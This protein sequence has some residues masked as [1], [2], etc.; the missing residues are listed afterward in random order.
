MQIVKQQLRSPLVVTAVAL[1]LGW[2]I[3][4][5]F[6]AKPPGISVAIFVLLLI[7]ALFGLGRWQQKLPEL[8]NLWL[9][10]PLFFFAVMVAV[11]DN[12]FL[13]AMN[14]LAVLLLLSYLAF[15][16]AHGRVSELDV[17]GSLL[18][19]LRV[20]LHS[21]VLTVPLL[22]STMEGV[23]LH[24]T[25]RYL[26]PVLRG[27]LLA[28]P[29]LFVF[30]ALLASA[31]L[32]FARQLERLLALEFLRGV[33]ELIGRAIIIGMAAWGLAGGLVYALA[34]RQTA[35]ATQSPLESW[36]QSLPRKYGLGFGES[37][38]ILS[39][40]NLLFLAFVGLQFTYL[41]GGE[42]HLVLEGITYA[43]Y[44][45]RGFFELV[46]VAVLSLALVLALNWATR[47][48]SKR[49]IRLFNALC[50]GLMALVLV[51]LLSAWRRMSL[52]EAAYGFTELRL[53]VFVFMAWLTAVLVWF[54]LTLWRAPHCFAIGLIVAAIGYLA[55]LDM[56][57]PDAFIV[58]Q[59]LARYA[60]T[61]DLDATYLTTLSADAVPAL[62]LALAQVQG[63][64]QLVPTPACSSHASRFENGDAESCQATPAEV[65]GANLH[66]R[67]Q[68]MQHDRTQTSWQSFHF[69]RLR[70]YRQLHSLYHP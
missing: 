47:R 60:Q 30:T 25:R 49:Q 17:P 62:R 59:N 11:R 44:A 12:P 51:M 39:L 68:A 22:A 15:F 26:L 54:L 45:R 69:S 27:G 42:R 40:V 55:T 61:G 10:L 1:L 23:H 50:S 35:V 13:T 52:Y 65:I 8:R 6:Y 66:G 3:D 58:R 63:D 43:A 48:A 7:A 14:I 36:L 29:I 9:L 5:L 37:I 24:P 53:Y 70:A 38:T 20:G 28:L 4:W 2:S 46:T 31:D 21:S 18:V 19:P 32:V 41:F 56:L 57:N 64:S 67:Y 16:Y 34:W 33:D